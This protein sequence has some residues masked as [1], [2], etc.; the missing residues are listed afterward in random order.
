MSAKLEASIKKLQPWYE[1][2]W[3]KKKEERKEKIS[4]AEK[5]AIFL[6][7][8]TL[9]NCESCVWLVA[10]SWRESWLKKW[11]IEEKAKK[12]ASIE[13]CKLKCESYRES[14]KLKNW[15]NTMK[16]KGRNDQSQ[17]IFL[18]GYQKT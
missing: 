5:Q 16:A 13:A 14:W 18:T 17:A 6:S 7:E 15:R 11:N 9:R 2:G 8:K 3:N 10:S 12:M 4:V 1:A